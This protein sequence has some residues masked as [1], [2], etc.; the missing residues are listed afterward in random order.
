MSLYF[1]LLIVLIRSWLGPSK[2]W[3]EESELRFRVLPT[4]CDLNLHLTSSRYIALSDL[5]RIH[6][7]GQTGIL[8]DIIKRRWF[9]FSAGVEV[10]YIRPIQP[11]QLFTVRT[12]ALTWDDKYW[13]SEHRFEV[14]DELRAIVLT[15]GLFVCGRKLV[16]MAEIAALTAENPPPP[17]VPETVEQWQLLLDAKK[18]EYPA[19]SSRKSA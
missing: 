7:L 3:S 5:G 6:L 10:T 2:P 12:R 18:R 16:S 14:A 11:F 1:R 4:D 19:A 17:P 8:G 13:Y 15:R 9:P